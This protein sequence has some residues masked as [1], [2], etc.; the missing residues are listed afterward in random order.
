MSFATRTL[1]VL[2]TVL[3]VLGICQAR[4]PP[5]PYNTTTQPLKADIFCTFP[6]GTLLEQVLALPDGR[7][8]VTTTV[9]PEVYI[10]DPAASSNDTCHTVLHH[11]EGFSSTFGIVQT[12]AHTYHVITSNYTGY[13]TLSGE[14]GSVTAWRIELE[15]HASSATSV[16]ELGV[17]PQA[18]I[19]DGI[20]YLEE[21][22]LIASGDSSTGDIWLIS[23]VT[24]QSWRAFSSAS[25][26]GPASNATD[27][28]LA[29]L[30]VNGFKYHNGY[31]YFTN[32][33][34]DIFG[35]I[36][37]DPKTGNV[38]G[39]GK[40]IANLAELQLDDMTFDGR[41]NA[42]VSETG[43]GVVLYPEI[44]L[45]NPAAKNKSRVLVDLYGANDCVFGR[46]EKDNGTLYIISAAQ[47][48]VAKV[49][50]GATWR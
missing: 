17:V 3:T 18:K 12:G 23:T 32:T 6:N 5:R 25:L 15:D 13:P 43:T 33:G 20:A 24:G 2:L 40:V 19:L 36:P 35:R 45:V 50:F 27:G 1:S 34:R 42:Y 14:E 4:S 31:Y 9:V 37:A 48:S 38:T 46:T 47:F 11:F 49:D 22:K 30:G 10:V 8:L 7:L 21:P 44:D 29:R 41:G 26:L 16:T 39:P 28:G